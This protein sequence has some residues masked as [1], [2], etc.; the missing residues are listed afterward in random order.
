MFVVEQT[1]LLKAY[2]KF[3]DSTVWVVCSRHLPKRD[4]QTIALFSFKNLL[5]TV[6]C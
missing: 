1:H 5:Q 2:K 6:R 3:A 4:L